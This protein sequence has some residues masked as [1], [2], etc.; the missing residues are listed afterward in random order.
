MEIVEG[1]LE[2]AGASSNLVKL[3]EMMVQTLK[4]QSAPKA[5]IDTFGGDPLEYIYFIESFKDVVEQLIDDP[6]QRLIRLY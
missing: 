1:S 4:L 6:K 3:S 5:D 2:G